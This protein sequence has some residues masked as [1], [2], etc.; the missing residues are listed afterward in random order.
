[1]KLVILQLQEQCLTTVMRGE[2]QERHDH[3]GQNLAVN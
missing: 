1:M 3:A 2:A